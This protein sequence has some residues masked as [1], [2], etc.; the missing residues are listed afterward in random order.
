MNAHSDDRGS[1]D[2]L[3]FIGTGSWAGKFQKFLGIVTHNGAP[4]MLVHE[5]TPFDDATYTD[6]SPISHAGAKRSL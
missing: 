3:M 2:S 1:G 5:R 4:V 6:R